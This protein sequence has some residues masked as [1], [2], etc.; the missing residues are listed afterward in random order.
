ME[1]NKEAKYLPAIIEESA[2]EEMHT[3]SKHGSILEIE[4]NPNILSNVA[5]TFQLQ[6][7]G[8]LINIDR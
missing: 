6:F 4:H 7:Q 3:E 5:Q 8:N 2:A 1:L